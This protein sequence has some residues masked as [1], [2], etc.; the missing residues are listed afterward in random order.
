[1]IVWIDSLQIH[2]GTFV[3]LDRDGVINIDRPHY[4]KHWT[5]FHFYTDALEALRSLNE[6]RVNVVVISNQSVLNRGFTTW[7]AF[8]GIHSGMV[9]EIRKA[10]GN[11]SAAFYCPHRPDENCTCRKPS[12][13]MILAASRLLDIRLESTWMVGDRETDVMAANAAGCRPVLLDRAPCEGLPSA[14]CCRKDGIRSYRTLTDFALN[15]S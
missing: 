13:G 9:Q 2:S 7:N 3:F 8:W 5:E 6:K 1:M 12:P 4:I 10:G 15:I 14:G 11:I